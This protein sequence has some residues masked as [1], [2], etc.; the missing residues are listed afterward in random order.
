MQVCGL[1]STS[2][3]GG[4][5]CQQL[6]GLETET[7]P[8]FAYQGHESGP[9]PPHQGLQQLH[10][11]ASSCFLFPR[12][13]H[14]P[15][16]EPSQA[17]QTPGSGTPGHLPEPVG[18]LGLAEASLTQH[19]RCWLG[20]TSAPLLHQRVHGPLPASVTKAAGSSVILAEVSRPLGVDAHAPD[21]PMWA[22][23]C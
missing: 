11:P 16:P 9:P 19:L 7:P 15:E 12:C 18:R 23:P 6:P 5:G 17:L 10:S 13:P 1:P 20:A 3:Q 2:V 8:L 4:D 14:S 22:D 21:F